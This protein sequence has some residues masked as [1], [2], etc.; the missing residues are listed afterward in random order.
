MA[1]VLD[2]WLNRFGIQP[3]AITTHQHVDLGGERADPR[4]FSWAELQTRLAALG[5]LCL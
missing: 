3:S 1:L 5:Q 2:E 4:S